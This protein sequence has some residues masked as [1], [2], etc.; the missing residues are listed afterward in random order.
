M[1]PGQK[2]LRFGGL[3]MRLLK[4]ATL[5]IPLALV[6]A[7]A[8]AD[9]VQLT[10]RTTSG[11]TTST[12]QI[13]I[14]RDHLRAE[15]GGQRQQTVIFDNTKQVLWMVNTDAKTYTEMTK[16]DVDR[17]SGQVSAAMATMQEQMKNLPPE[18]RARI[19]EMMKG[20]GMGGAAAASKT[21][22]KKVGSDKVGKWNCDKYEGS[23]DGQKVVELCT[24]E[25]G[26]LGFTMADFAVATELGNFFKSLAPQNADRLFSVGAQGQGFS[27]VP[28]RRVTFLNGQ[29]EMVHEIVDV[30]RQ[31]FPASTF[32]VP[33]GFQKQPFMG[34]R[35]RQ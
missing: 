11:G 9:G 30:T 23:R 17:L 15:T 25:P 7:A 35:G 32:E 14:D 12:H 13:Q 18:Q 20:R 22:Y 10:E 31:T 28:V 29:P 1:A 16:A 5:T 34:G 26:A 4:I 21:E 27:G 19:E 8:A 3:L 2:R 24:V 6:S 33:A